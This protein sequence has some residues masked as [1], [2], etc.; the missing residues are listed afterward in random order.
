M[1]LRCWEVASADTRSLPSWES[2]GRPQRPQ[3]LNGTPRGH[4]SKILQKSRLAQAS[5]NTLDGAQRVLDSLSKTAAE[6]P[7]DCDLAGGEL[8]LP[9]Q[10]GS[11]L[12]PGEKDRFFGNLSGTQVEAELRRLGMLVK[13]L[14]R[15]LTTLKDAVWRLQDERYEVKHKLETFER[16]GLDEVRSVVAKS[17]G[18]LKT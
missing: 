8:I 11:S 3:P 7:E 10:G 15:D 12:P 18:H 1:R 6:A 4:R 16:T 14:L 9:P 13:G 17:N 5:G 2:V